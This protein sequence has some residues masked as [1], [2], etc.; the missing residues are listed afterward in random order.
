VNTGIGRLAT[1]LGLVFL[2]GACALVYQVLWLRRLSLTFGVTTYAATAVLASFMAGLALGSWAAGRLADRVRS[3]LRLFGTVELGIALSAAATPAVLDLA[4]DLYVWVFSTA[5]RPAAASTVVRF[6]LAFVVLVIP[7]SLMGATL[8][9][10]VRAAIARRDDVGSRGGWLYASN[11]AGAIVGCLVTGF[12]LLPHVGSARSFWIASAVNLL[13]GSAAWLL[14]RSRSPAAAMPGAPEPEAARLR[15]GRE[16]LVLAVLGVSGL[17]SL[18]LEVVWFRVLGVMLGPTSYAFTI[19]LASVLA[20]IAIGSAFAAP[21]LRWRGAWWPVLGLIQMA[22]GLLA[23]GS[24]GYLRTVPDL[25]RVIAGIVPT[26]MAFLL[27]ALAT[28][29]FAILPTAVLWGIAFPVALRLWVGEGGTTADVARRTG[30][31]YAANVLGGVVGA[32]AAGFVLLPYVGARGSLIVLAG[33]FSASGLVLIGSHARREWLWILPAL[34]GVAWF[35]TRAVDVPDPREAARVRLHSGGRVL[36]TADGP[37]STVTVVDDIGLRV[38][39]INGRHQANDSSNMVFIHRRIGL[40]GAVLHADPRSA[41]V[42]GVGGGVTPGALGQFPGLRVDAVELS[43]GVLN[44][45]EFFRTVNFDVLRQ[46]NVRVTVDDGRDVLLTSGRR[47]DVITAD[48]VPARVAGSNNLNSIEY[49]RLVR[50]RLHPGGVA[51]HWNAGTTDAEYRLILRT[52]LAAFPH[53]TLWG[54]GTLMVG[55]ETALTVSESRLTALLADGPSRDALRLMHVETF[56]HLLRMF[57]ARRTDVETWIGSGPILSDDRPVLEYFTEIPTA[58]RD[59]AQLVR[60]LEG[61]VVR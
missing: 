23:L 56:D 31:L 28:G 33:V 60:N 9:I 13:V 21:L 15:D 37:Q 41:L 49:F 4:H 18:A 51:V 2:S 44:G 40:L 1:L 30:V 61:L 11:T 10:V 29:V 14:G 8:P 32:I 39:Y 45:A 6:V 38:M 34:G 7:T 22:I 42:V 36:F 50:S 59:V 54:D 25:P 53:V 57:R 5:A 43:A 12:V 46:P 20:G 26:Q 24:F 48:A 27:P 19:M 47:Y 16:P 58:E 55:T 3:P 35:A 17:A 52:F